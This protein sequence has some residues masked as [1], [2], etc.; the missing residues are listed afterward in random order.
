M[1]SVLYCGIEMV[2][3]LIEKYNCSV[4]CRE[5]TGSTPFIAACANGKLDIVHYLLKETKI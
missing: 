2:K 3:L 4:N 1:L 5:N